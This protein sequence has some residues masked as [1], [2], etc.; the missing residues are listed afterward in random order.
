M[1]RGFCSST[2]AELMGVLKG[3]IVAWE[4]GHKKVEVGLDSE[5]V[6]RMLIGDSYINSQYCH[7]VR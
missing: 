5:I 3:L 4:G 1:N 7:I 6:V 2:K